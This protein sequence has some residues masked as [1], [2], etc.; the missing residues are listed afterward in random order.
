MLI[1]R[2]DNID[3]LGSLCSYRQ[4]LDTDTGLCKDL[5]RMHYGLD[6]VAYPCFDD[7]GI[8]NH[9]ITAWQRHVKKVACSE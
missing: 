3:F 4:E 5:D 1:I 9:N 2:Q 7:S 8:I 6:G